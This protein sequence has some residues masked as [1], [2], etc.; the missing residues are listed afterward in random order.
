MTAGVE[1]GLQDFMLELERILLIKPVC[2]KLNLFS[3]NFSR[4]KI[5]PQDLIEINRDTTLTAQV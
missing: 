5:A 3:P 4:H 1:T 2:V